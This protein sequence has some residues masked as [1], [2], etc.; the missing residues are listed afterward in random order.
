MSASKTKGTSVPAIPL[1]VIALELK[2]LQIITKIAHRD[3][4]LR[5]TSNLNAQP[6]ACKQNLAIHLNRRFSTKL[7][8]S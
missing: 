4:P 5:Y 1:H 6:A 3:N 2:Y 8:A 7:A